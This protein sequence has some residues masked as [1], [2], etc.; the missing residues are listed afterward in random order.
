LRRDIRTLG[1]VQVR[2]QPKGVKPPIRRTQIK[3]D[4]NWE[5]A[6]K[7]GGVKPRTKKKG[8]LYFLYNTK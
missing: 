8:Y 6:L 3:K 4:V 2:S 1:S 5:E 7:Q